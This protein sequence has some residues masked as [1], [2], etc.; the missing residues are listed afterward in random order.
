MKKLTSFLML[1]L[2]L[3]GAVQAGE[4]TLI[5]PEALQARIAKKDASLVVLDVRTPEEFAAGHVPGAR[6]IPHDQLDS[7]LNELLGIKDKEIVLYCRSGR[8][9]ALAVDTLKANGFNKLLHLDGDMQKWTA[10]NR[11]TEK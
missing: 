10:D 3:V 6:N 8:R 2:F 11:A 5:A 9:T 4:A 1:A 7:R